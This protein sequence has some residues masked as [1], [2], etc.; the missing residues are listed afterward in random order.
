MHTNEALSAITLQQ[1]AHNEVSAANSAPSSVPIIKPI[2]IPIIQQEMILNML[3][4]KWNEEIHQGK[5]LKDKLLGYIDEGYQLTHDINLLENTCHAFHL[6]N[7]SQVNFAQFCQFIQLPPEMQML[8]K[9]NT[10]ENFFIMRKITELKQNIS[11][12]KKDNQ[13]LT[14]ALSNTGGMIINLRE[15]LQKINSI[16]ESQN[17]YHQPT[18]RFESICSTNRVQGQSFFQ[19]PNSTRPREKHYCRQHLEMRK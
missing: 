4:A 2:S 3:I 1:V 6:G 11:I 7:N 8:S 19:Q 14:I 18:S 9:F 12:L 17:N 15:R 13:M 10:K 5:I 16:V